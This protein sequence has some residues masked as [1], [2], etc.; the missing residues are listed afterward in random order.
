MAFSECYEGNPFVYRLSNISYLLQCSVHK[1]ALVKLTLYCTKILFDFTI[2]ADII[3]KAHVLSIATDYELG[4]T[5]CPMSQTLYL[6]AFVNGLNEKKPEVVKYSQ[7]A[8]ECQSQELL[9]FVKSERKALNRQWAQLSQRQD[10]RHKLLDCCIT[11]WDKC[12]AVQDDLSGLE[13][14]ICEWDSLA[15]NQAMLALHS[16]MLVSS[17][18]WTTNWEKFIYSAHYLSLP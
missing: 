13:Q 9:M 2:Y 8:V 6:K 14:Q 17:R 10:S 18:Q 12:L 16:D 11:T 3:D 5:I 7:L 15:D 4:L 1:V